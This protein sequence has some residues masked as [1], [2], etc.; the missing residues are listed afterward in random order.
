MT[1][2]RS[3][4]CEKENTLPRDSPSKQF[5]N[6]LNLFAHA[7]ALKYNMIT[8][9]PQVSGS[10]ALVDDQSIFKEAVGCVKEAPHAFATI[11]HKLTE[12]SDDRS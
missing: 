1:S 11:S 3:E 5:N 7:T 2:T 4:F 8:A 6:S 12:A 10:Y 9:R